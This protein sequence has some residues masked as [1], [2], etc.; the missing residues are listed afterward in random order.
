MFMLGSDKL[1]LWAVFMLCTL[2]DTWPQRERKLAPQVPLTLSASNL[3]RP[4][5]FTTKLC[6]R[7]P[8]PIEAVEEGQ[9]SLMEMEKWFGDVFKRRGWMKLS[10]LVTQEGCSDLVCEFY[11]NAV[12]PESDT[13]VKPTFQ[14]YCR[15]ATIDY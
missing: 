13:R 11:A 15:G 4:R 8:S 2:F 5:P 7:S 12:E 10:K 1:T 9:H 6:L 3:R 14:S